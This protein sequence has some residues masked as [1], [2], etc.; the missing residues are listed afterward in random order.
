MEEL[1]DADTIDALRV[2][3]DVL[4]DL[5]SLAGEAGRTIAP[6][7]ADE[8]SA[9]GAQEARLLGTVVDVDVAENTLPTIRTVANKPTLNEVKAKF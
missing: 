5:A 2:G 1:V 7:V 9:V 6:E 4:L 8:V 3:A